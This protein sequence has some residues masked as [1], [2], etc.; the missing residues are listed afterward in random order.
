MAGRIAGVV[1]HGQH[2]PVRRALDLAADPV[3]RLAVGGPLHAEDGDRPSPPPA[4][5][6]WPLM[7][8]AAISTAAVATPTTLGCWPGQRAI[9]GPC[10]R[11]QESAPSCYVRTASRY[12]P[13]HPGLVAGRAASVT[14]RRLLLCVCVCVEGRLEVKVGRPWTSDRDGGEQHEQGREAGVDVPV[15]HRPAGLGVAL[16]VGVL[17][18]KRHDQHRGRLRTVGDPQVGAQR[19]PEA[20]GVG[21]LVEDQERVA[22]AE[23]GRGAR[24]PFARMRWRASGLTGWSV[25]ARTMRRRRRTCWNSMANSFMDGTASRVSILV[26]RL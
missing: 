10:K 15:R 4:L 19:L 14:V 20:G 16:E 12:E 22:L 11:S 5:S 25:N 21:R 17:V 18:G 26:G 13:S 8:R 1:G 3:G 23:A 2:R 7:S 24:W 9:V 6:E